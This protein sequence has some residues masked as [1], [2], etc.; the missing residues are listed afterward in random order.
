MAKIAAIPTADARIEATIAEGGRRYGRLAHP[1]TGR[2]CHMTDTGV[3]DTRSL[4]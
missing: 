4:A 2:H 3:T 1:I